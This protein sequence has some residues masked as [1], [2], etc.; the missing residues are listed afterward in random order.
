L[1]NDA[2][3]L[4]EISSLDELIEA[5]V[6]ELSNTLSRSHTLQELE[7]VLEELSGLIH[8]FKHRHELVAK[9]LDSSTTKRSRSQILQTLDAMRIKVDKNGEE[10]ALL[11]AKSQ[12]LLERSEL[13]IAKAQR[14]IDKEAHKHSGYAVEACG[15]CA[16]V[17]KRLN[18]PCPACKGRGSVLVQQD[19]S[20]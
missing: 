20:R 14:Q 5:Y 12:Q 2:T 10:L 8:S 19:M 16:G 17:G 13:L 18:A 4:Q 1:T 7:A 3:G 11:H 9:L 6:R 15:L